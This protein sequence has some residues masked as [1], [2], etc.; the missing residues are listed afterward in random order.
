VNRRILTSRLAALALLAAFPFFAAA[1]SSGPLRIVVPTSAGGPLDVVA[2]MLAKSLAQNLNDT[3]IVDNRP[4]AAGVIGT[5]FV[6]K[7]RPDGRTLLLASG[8]VIT[9]PVLYKVNYDPLRDFEPVAE[10]TQAPMVLLA[11]KG[12]DVRVPADLAKAAALQRGGLNCAASPGEMSL[13]C[14]QLKQ[15]LGGAVVTVPYPGMAP[16]ITAL[17]GG[18][19][20]V[21][22]STYDAALPMLQEGRVT[23]VATTGVKSALPPFHLLPTLS[24][25]WPSFKVVG[26]IAILAPAG[27][28]PAV[29]NAL[30]REFNLALRD[31]QVSAFM[32]ARGSVV[33]DDGTP[34][35][36]GQLLAD[37]AAH[38]RRLAQSLGIK[39]E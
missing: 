1:Q 36:L 21:M 30:N 4:G 3:V 17:A 28:P 20:D 15:V 9:N 13:A 39:P 10:L 2:R 26:F 32:A 16:A 8:F 19:V 6:A 11:R 33:P 31:P 14:E 29:V 27:T 25:T 38:Y 5:E 12:L 18:Q 34:A 22:V 24:D 35:S 7:A 37:R 23:A